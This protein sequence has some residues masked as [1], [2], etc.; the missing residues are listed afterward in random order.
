MGGSNPNPCLR[1]SVAHWDSA[2]LQRPLLGPQPM[3]IVQGLRKTEFNSPLMPADQHSS[4]LKASLGFAS[5]L[6]TD[7]LQSIIS[8]YVLTLSTS[9][10]FCCWS[11]AVNLNALAADHTFTTATRKLTLL[12]STP[13]PAGQ[14]FLHTEHLKRSSTSQLRPPGPNL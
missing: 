14:H 10:P 11:A 5:S 8:S 12:R 1:R 13:V 7:A 3:M 4:Y 6:T 9:L 2:N